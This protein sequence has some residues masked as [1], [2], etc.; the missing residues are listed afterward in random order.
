MEWPRS[1]GW[2]SAAGGS[3]G[4]RQL[5]AVVA[6]IEFAHAWAACCP[7]NILSILYQAFPRATRRP[8]LRRSKQYP[9]L[10][11]DPPP[12]ACR[13][14]APKHSQQR[15]LGAR[16]LEM[17]VAGAP[18]RL[19]GRLF[20]ATTR[21]SAHGATSLPVYQRRQLRCSAVAAS[22]AAELGGGSS[23]A[24]GTA[25]AAASPLAPLDPL[26]ATAALSQDQSLFQGE[27]FSNDAEDDAGTP[28]VL[29]RKLGA[30]AGE[31]SSTGAF[32]RLP[33]VAP[34]KELLNSALR[35]AARAPYNNK[36]KNEA[37]KAK[38]R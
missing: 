32:Q 8:S 14:S 19:L 28:L 13:C 21:Q 31:A 37:Q 1:A 10:P 26:A 33:M 24:A 20:L 18:C 36:L 30:D 9:T 12:A 34:S 3:G 27:A 29:P 17:V 38:N 11:L 4:A 35:R 2:W 16:P 5:A 7:S 22:S 15:M 6:N 25:A 23:R